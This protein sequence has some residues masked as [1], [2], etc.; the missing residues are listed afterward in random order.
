MNVNCKN[1]EFK[2]IP[3]SKIRYKYEKEIRNGVIMNNIGNATMRYCGVRINCTKDDL[4]DIICRLDLP[5]KD[6]RI[7]YMYFICKIPEW[8]LPIDESESLMY[9]PNLIKAVA[10]TLH[11]NW[12]FKKNKLKP[13]KGHIKL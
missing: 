3:E 9:L 7:L 2:R 6:I 8:R 13:Q 10:T 11:S 1:P 12:N 5:K 4:K